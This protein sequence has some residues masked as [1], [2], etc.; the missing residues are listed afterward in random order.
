MSEEESDYEIEYEI[1]SVGSAEPWDDTDGVWVSASG[2]T[3]STSISRSFTQ[4]LE[5]KEQ[6]Q[7]KNTRGDEGELQDTTSAAP[8]QEEMNKVMAPKVNGSNEAVE[9]DGRHLKYEDIEELMSEIGNMR[10]SLRLMPDFQRR[11]MAANLAMKMAAMFG[12]GSDE[13]GGI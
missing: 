7:E 6:D 10:D 5:I 1:L 9:E 13:E 3:A 2:P 11:E 4:D 12:D 8:S